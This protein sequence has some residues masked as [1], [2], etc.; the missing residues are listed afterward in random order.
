MGEVGVAGS[1]LVTC[2]LEGLGVLTRIGFRHLPG[3]VRIAPHGEDLVLRQIG[4]I[5]AV[6]PDHVEPGRIDELARP[7]GRRTRIPCVRI[8]AAF[9]ADDGV[10][11]HGQ[12][13][14][15]AAMSDIGK[16]RMMTFR[17]MIELRGSD[18]WSP[19]RPIEWASLL[20][21]LVPGF[22]VVHLI[23]TEAGKIG[24]YYGRSLGVWLES[25]F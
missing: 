3:E 5:R 24:G 12:K 6:S 21:M 11:V 17:E 10:Y 13:E 8:S 7:V 16:K 25:L 4:Q 18:G 2:P 23:A 14:G 19:R 9:R 22:W 20:A 15:A 1:G